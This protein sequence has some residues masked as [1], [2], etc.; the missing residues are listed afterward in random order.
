MLLV[1]NLFMYMYAKI[2][3]IQLALTK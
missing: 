1:E 3:E 2:I